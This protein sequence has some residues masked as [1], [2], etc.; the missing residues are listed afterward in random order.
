MFGLLILSCKKTHLVRVLFIS[1]LLSMAGFAY[2]EGAQ[3]TDKNTVLELSIIGNN[4]LPKVSFNLPW[5]LPSVEKR[6]DQ[7]PSRDL[8]GVLSPLEPDQHKKYVY[9]S[10]YLELDIPELRTR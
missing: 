10:R 8:K 3:N 2:S 4:E 1:L 7:S 9:F 6:E 5:R